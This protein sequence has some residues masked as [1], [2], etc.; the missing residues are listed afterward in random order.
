MAANYAEIIKV[1]KLR[2]VF[3]KF[4]VFKFLWNFH[5]TAMKYK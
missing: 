4:H 3:N 5:D 1:G 2:N